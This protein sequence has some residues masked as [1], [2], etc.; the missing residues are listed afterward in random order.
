MKAH[1]EENATRDQSLRQLQTI[2]ASSSP[3][4][5]KPAPEAGKVPDLTGKMYLYG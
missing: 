2:H 4:F 5:S 3:P 1:E